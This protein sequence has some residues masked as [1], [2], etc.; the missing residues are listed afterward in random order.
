MG[1]TAPAA[2]RAAR[3]RRADRWEERLTVPVIIA[4]LVS[5]PAVFLTTAEAGH[6]VLTGH[7][8]NWAS[9][10][11]LT[12]ESALL[13]L[14]TGNRLRWMWRHRWPLLIL[15]ISIPAVLLAIAPTQTLRLV[16]HLIRF[17]GALRI[18]RASRIVRAGRV[19]ARRIG[20]AGPW[21]YLPILIG[22]LVA[23][24]FVVLVLSD[25]ASASR[26]AIAQIPGRA[27]MLAVVLGGAILGT[28][29]F[30]L[31]RY[32]WRRG[33]LRPRSGVADRGGEPVGDRSRLLH[34]GRFDHY[35][36]Q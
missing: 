19:L 25:P 34:S 16:L 15:A 21:R 26:Q 22:S 6:L 10:L 33:R 4:A 20:W 27:G 7:L 30:I 36:D 8:L 23:A 17:F 24:G 5:V 3:D 18:L 12:A 32:R 29:T 1:A 31:V 11:V 13:F 9:L 2:D 35:P 14:L 28:A